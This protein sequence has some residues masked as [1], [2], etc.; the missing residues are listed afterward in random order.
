MN[1][2]AA[3]CLGDPLTMPPPLLKAHQALDRAV[4]AAYGVKG[5]KSEAE[6]VAFL[7]QRYQALSPTL[8]Q[9]GEN[10]HDIRPRLQ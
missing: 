6:R 7:F 8:P 4:G 3:R 5:F 1:S 9:T 2:L 10:K